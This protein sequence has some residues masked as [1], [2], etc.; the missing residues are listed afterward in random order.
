M[1]EQ[2]VETSLTNPPPFK[3]LPFHELL[4]ENERAFLVENGQIRSLESG[5]IICHQ[6]KLEE[7]LYL[8]LLGE[9]EIV[10]EFKAQQLSIGKLSTGDIVGEIG[11]LFSIPRIASVVTTLPT[12]VL[13]ISPTDFSEMIGKTPNLEGIVYRQLYERSLQTA[14]CSTSIEADSE[15]S[16]NLGRL[17]SFWK[18]QEIN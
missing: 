7:V 17:L 14:L 12:V 1:S 11:A 5:E 3:Y 10:E 6:N 4:S 8:I 2:N 15:I 16:N 18:I 9:V 13:E